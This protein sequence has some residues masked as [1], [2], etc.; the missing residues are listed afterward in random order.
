MMMSF[1]TK[2]NRA[3][4]IIPFYGSAELTIGEE[5]KKIRG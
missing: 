1:Q 5:V 3:F 2:G 4:A